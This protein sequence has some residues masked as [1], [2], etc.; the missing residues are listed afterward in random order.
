M[1]ETTKINSQKNKKF[2]INIDL[3]KEIGRKEDASAQ[4]MRILSV[5]LIQN[6]PENSTQIYTDASKIGQECGYGFFCAKN[7]HSERV[8]LNNY[9]SI[10]SAELLAIR[11]ALQYAQENSISEAVVLT[12]SLSSCQALQSQSKLTYISEVALDI[13]ELL[14]S[15]HSSI[16]WIPSHVGIVGNEKAD[17]LA[18][19][20]IEKG[21]LINNKIRQPDATALMKNEL[22][23][24]QQRSYQKS[25][26][27]DKFKKIYQEIQPF[28]WFHKCSLS[29]VE[30]KQINRLISNHSYDKRWLHRYGKAE[31][32]TC[33]ACE[34]VETAEHIIFNCKKHEDAKKNYKY[35]NQLDSVEELWRS[36]HRNEAIKEISLLIR[37]QNI[38][39]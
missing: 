8:K 4:V 34:V 31:S 23:E 16:V 25:D 5:A 33:E 30:I 29:G 38:E 9:A 28:S 20:G 12:D 27:G 35:M 6:L 11:H 26:K 15:T 1:V 10:C 21:T 32:E 19:E 39:F 17:E 22:R 3:H 37:Q 2:D 24:N 7:N 14:L 36:Q 18:K 13:L